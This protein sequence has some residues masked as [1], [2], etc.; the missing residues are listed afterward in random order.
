MKFDDFDKKENILSE[1]GIEINKIPKQEI[2]GC[3]IYFEKIEKVGFNST[4]NT[5]ETTTRRK[6]CINHELP[7]GDEYPKMILRFAGI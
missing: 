4:K 7:Q 1:Y 3:G 5:N 2:Y 6:L